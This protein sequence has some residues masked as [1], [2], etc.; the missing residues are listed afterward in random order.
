MATN[1][2]K[3]DLVTDLDPM[4][5]RIA[6]R[7]AY[8]AMGETPDNIRAHMKQH[9]EGDGMVLGDETR[10]RQIITNLAS[11]A[12]KFTPSGGSLRITTTLV[13]P[14]RDGCASLTTDKEGTHTESFAN[15]EMSD[16]K[17]SGTRPS[18]AGTANQL[19]LLSATH[20]NQ[21]NINE[22]K[23]KVRTPLEWIVVRIEVSDTGCGIRSKDMAQ[24]K[25]FCKYS[26]RSQVDAC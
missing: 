26:V 16:E 18:T 22:D 3:L 5:D 14:N 17:V 10:L 21:H 19:H 24:S 20:L 9:P 4:I 11:N 13:A 8:D 15:S 1:A 6:R 2:R 7:A 12:C 23:S 25:L